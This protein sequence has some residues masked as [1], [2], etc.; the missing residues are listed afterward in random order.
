MYRW[1]F[2]IGQQLI[3]V[4][5]VCTGGHF[6]GHNLIPVVTCEPEKFTALLC[7]VARG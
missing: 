5:R 3:A 7:L 6:L 2:L 4:G 1:V